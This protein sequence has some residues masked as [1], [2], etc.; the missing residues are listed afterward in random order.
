MFKDLVVGQVRGPAVGGEDGF[1]QLKMGQVEP[2]GTLVVE[3][4]GMPARRAEAVVIMGKYSR[5]IRIAI[6]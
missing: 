6:V 1:I 5:D 4:G 2:G 3:V